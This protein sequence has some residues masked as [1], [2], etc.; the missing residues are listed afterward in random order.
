M[1]DHKFSAIFI[2]LLCSS[3]YLAATQRRL[4]DAHLHNTWILAPAGSFLIT[5]FFIVFTGYN[6]SYWLLLIPL[7]MMVVLLTYPSKS[8]RRYTL[9]YNG[10]VNLSDFQQLKKTNSRNSQR[11]EPTMN[12]VNINQS[13]HN[14]NDY[15]PLADNSQNTSSTTSGS[16][17]SDSTQDKTEL[18]ESIRLALFSKKK[19]Q[20]FI[21]LISFLLV[22][23]FI[24]S[25]LFDK[26]TPAKNPVEH[27]SEIQKKAKEFQHQITLP[28]NFSI[29]IA[30][31]NAIVIQW[32]ASVEDNLNVWALGNAEGDKSCKI[33]EFTKA[34]VIRTYSVS[35][36]DNKYYAYFS[37]LDTKALI[38][39]IAF[40]NKFSLCG[41]SFSL[42]GSQARLG[43][44]S[45]Y[46]NL[47]E[48]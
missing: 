28:D 16:H 36:I 4:N 44:S 8:Q 1:S 23:A 5:G 20:L 46:A 41:Y 19:S 37:P 32:Q 34:E 40:K 38:K 6:S 15:S 30:A 47:I 43:K 48:Y 35:T 33:I 22:L 12:S 2:L 27:T 18:A 29:M 3:T 39:N 9:G 17:F 31:N 21:A 25:M 10:P 24:I 42:K 13:L 11:I 45:F 14:K 7:L 26:Q